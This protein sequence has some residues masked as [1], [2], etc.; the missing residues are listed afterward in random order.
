MYRDACQ[1]D[2]LRYES[3]LRDAEGEMRAFVERHGLVMPEQL[4]REAVCQHDAAAMKAGTIPKRGNLQ[5]A[6]AG[7]WAETLTANDKDSLRPILN[8]ALGELGYDGDGDW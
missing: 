5:V 8:G 7:G 1:I 4:L 2:I 6:R 3:W